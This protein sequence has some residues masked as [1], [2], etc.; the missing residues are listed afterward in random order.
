MVSGTCA[1][2]FWNKFVPDDYISGDKSMGELQKSRE[3]IHNPAISFA[4]KMV[5]SN[6]FKLLFREGMGLVEE[7]AAYLDGDGRKE[8]RDLSRMAAL[9]YASES[10][11]LTT[12]L[13]QMT[14][15]LLLQ[16]AVNEGELSQEEAA[17]EHRKV[18]LKAQDSVRSEEMITLLP[19]PLQDLIARSINMQNRIMKLDAVL[20][21][22]EEFVPQVENTV[23][24]RFGAL[25]AAINLR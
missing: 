5:S 6:G 11:R 21:G 1:V 20:T 7:T 2:R 13:M 23:A 18:K 15:W 16:R 25:Q 8:A 19:A 9:A 3:T 17:T 10:M 24:A 12:R 4:R 14:S 22:K